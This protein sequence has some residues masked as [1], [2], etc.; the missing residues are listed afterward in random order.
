MTSQNTV[1][2][3]L[4]Y[5]T[6]EHSSLIPHTPAIDFDPNQKD[7]TIGGFARLQT[8]VSKIRNEKLKSKEPVL[9]VSAGDFLSGNPYSWL[10]TKG[11][12]PELSLMNKIGYDV[13]TLGN[14]EYD[15]G[16]DFISN[17]LKLAGYPKDNGPVL[18][19]TNTV[20]YDDT[21]L[22]EIGLNKYFIKELTNN[23]KVGFIGIIGKEAQ[24]YIRKAKDITFNSH[25]TSIKKY[26][27]TLK[28]NG[29]NIIVAVNHSGVNENI[30][31][32]RYIDDIDIIIS[33]HTHKFLKHPT[34]TNNTFIVQPGSHLRHLGQLDISYNIESKELSIYQKNIPI[35]D[36]IKEDP[37]IESDISNYTNLLNEWLEDLTNKKINNIL[38]PIAI[39]NENIKKT[40]TY[41]E[42]PLGNLITDSMRIYAEDTL[43]K[44]VDFAFQVNGQ[45]RDDILPGTRED[46]KGKISFYD[47]ARTAGMGK[48]INS[49]PGYP[50]AE[51]YFTKREIKIILESFIFLSK[52]MGNPLFLQV[53]GMRYSYDPDN[54]ILSDLPIKN[55]AIPSFRAINSI[56]KY[57]GEGVQTDNNKDFIELKKDK[58]KLYRVAID[59]Y[60]LEFFPKKR[61]VSRLF[62]VPKDEHG[63]PIEDFKKSI[64]KENYRPLTVWKAL[65]GFSKN[66]DLT[67]Y[68][69]DNKRIITKN[70][71]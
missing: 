25:L 45:I 17:Y 64:I 46:T 28:E 70:R 19:G 10:A 57:V 53:S 51:V 66:R 47:L 37:E 71:N 29:A 62:V 33:G 58:K 42:T 20:I 41:S 40:P 63:N 13:I 43:E 30:N 69:E 35:D 8:I 4:L 36:I 61:L 68:S 50:V 60:V 7:D 9:L 5:T 2:F 27:K 12:T 54:V 44:T 21:P 3:T 1:N 16:T 11:K 48:T 59:L 26:V 56:E 14:H 38:E 18:L 31:I 6:D 67:S 22:K 34:I 32:A 39:S 55:W 15:F 65:V 49:T 52:V 24:H 23:I